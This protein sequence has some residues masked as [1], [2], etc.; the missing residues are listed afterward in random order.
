MAALLEHF[1]AL[2]VR[3]AVLSF[4]LGRFLRSD[5]V[6][7]V[8]ADSNAASRLWSR[9]SLRVRGAGDKC[10]QGGDKREEAFGMHDIHLRSG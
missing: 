7:S 9:N 1:Q 3:Q 8:A 5:M 10:E 2:P 6:V 4:D